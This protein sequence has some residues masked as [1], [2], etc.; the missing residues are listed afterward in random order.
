MRYALRS[1]FDKISQPLD[2]ADKALYFD[3][4]MTKIITLGLIFTS[5]FSAS[6]A[7][8]IESGPG[9]GQGLYEQSGS[10]SCMYCHGI[11]GKNGKIAAAANLTQPKTWKVYKALGGDSAYAKNSAE[12]LKNM[13][14]A[15]LDLIK[16]GAVIHNSAFKKPYFDWSKTG[17]QY[18]AQMLGLGGAPSVAWLKKY[19]EKGVDKDIAAKSVYLYVQKF[20]TQGVFKK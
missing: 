12:F 10:N 5:L 19:K 18:N 6:M 1:R 15:T 11:E 16:G 2:L 4:P 17:G 8:A 3:I 14:E 13:E 9:M 7:Q 20:D